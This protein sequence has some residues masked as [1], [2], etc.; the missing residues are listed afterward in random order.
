MTATLSAFLLIA[1]NPVKPGIPENTISGA[2]RV[3][4]ER[5]LG[6]LETKNRGLS[7]RI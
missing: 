4:C 2:G 7:I 5:V 6:T 1:F 3:H